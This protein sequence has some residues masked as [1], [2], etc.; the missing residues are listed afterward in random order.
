MEITAETKNGYLIQ[1]SGSEIREI[2]SAV[3]GTKPKEISIGQRIPAI[4]YATTITKIK[5]LGESYRFLELFKE[6]KRF[7]E[8]AEELKLA[9][10]K[11]GEIEV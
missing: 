4:D 3:T 11:A 6:L 10:E 2:L 8:D 9:V 7:N 1:A 5:A